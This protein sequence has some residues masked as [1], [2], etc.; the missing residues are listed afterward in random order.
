M[1]KIIY[2]ITLTLAVTF[3]GCN[4][5]EDLYDDIDARETPGVDF[6]QAD[7]QY[8]FTAE[9]Y[10]L[11]EDELGGEE[12]FE[13]QDQADLILPD[14]LAEKYPVWGE[15]SLV[16][17]TYNLFDETVLEPIST[18]QTLSNLNDIDSFLSTTIE[19]AENGTFVELTYNAEVL[20]YT[21]S[22]S[23]FETIEDALGSK[24]PE[25]TSSAARFG[26][27]ERR[28]GRDSYWSDNMIVEAITALLA[29][30]YNTGQV[31]VVNFAIFDGSPGSESFTLQHNG[32]NFLK[33]DVE[34]SG[35]D[36]TEYTLTGDDYDAIAA[37]LTA[38]YPGPG[39]NLA[40][41]G[42][43]DVRVGSSDNAWTDEMLVEGFN[44]VLPSATEGDVYVVS[45][46]IFNGSR[47][48]DTMTLLYTGG[49]YIQSATVVEVATVVAKNDGDWEFPYTFT[50]ADYD[51]FG[52][53]FP[54]FSSS[55]IYI[56]DI[57]LEGLFPFAQAGDVAM[58]QYDFFAGGTS[59]KYGHSVFDGDKWKLTPDVIET[60]FQ[61]GFEDGVWVPDNTINY[62]LLGADVDLISNALIDVYPG[63]ADNVG[64][65]GSFDRRTGSSNYWSDEMLLEAFNILLDTRNPGAAEGQ[66]YALTF[67][68]FTGSTG[69]ETKSVIKTDGVWVY[70]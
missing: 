44:L 43:F 12:F 35:S 36:A 64:F 18:S 58:V 7:E 51:S 8:T 24:Y 56:L 28:S 41:F 2:L 9:D 37:A 31:L 27:F 52:F 20:A 33:L 3:V 47:G 70:Q 11:Y 60:S 59:T 38:T 25:A 1:K 55:N 30:D 26:N 34:A 14:F 17:V 67:V 39:G 15:G 21:L 63:P 62:V 48:T 32:Y 10:E 29:A 50:R 23:D 40:Q 57:F 53:R 5:L 66:K 16:N 6:I 65:F 42:S 54:N 61:Y 22:D 49:A 69:N 19:S 4:P 45:Y 13:S 68:V 46:E